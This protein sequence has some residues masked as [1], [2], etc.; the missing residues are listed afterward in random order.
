MSDVPAS[1]AP[2]VTLADVERLQAAAS[3]AVAALLVLV[4]SRRVGERM[5]FFR[6]LRP[7]PGDYAQV[8]VPPALRRAQAFYEAMW[9]QPMQTTWNLRQTELRVAA[10]LAQDFTDW[11]ARA[12]PFPGGYR[13]VAPLLLPGVIWMRWEMKEPGELYGLS[14]DGL[15]QLGERLVWFPRPFVAL[16]APLPGETS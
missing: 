2:P 13:D 3:A 9:A 11:N 14:T 10:A 5:D 7:Q 16:M 6:T 8:F 15:V 4:D 1:A 12:E